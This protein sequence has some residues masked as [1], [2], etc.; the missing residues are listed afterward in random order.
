ME[1]LQLQ[2]TAR[3]RPSVGGA[4]GSKGM[5]KQ[6]KGVEHVS[7][8]ESLLLDNPEIEWIKLKV[9]DDHNI[10]VGL[11]RHR[12]A[13]MGRI[14]VAVYRFRN[15]EFMG[16]EMENTDLMPGTKQ[17]FKKRDLKIAR[18]YYKQLCKSFKNGIVVWKGSGKSLLGKWD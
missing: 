11:Y 7:D 4:V 10:A 14:H 3:D 18:W 9:F 16:L 13:K 17:S 6:E 1:H 8:F 12:Y 5:N 2:V 15:E